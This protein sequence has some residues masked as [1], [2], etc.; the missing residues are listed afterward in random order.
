M[1][2]GLKPKWIQ[3]KPGHAK[4]TPPGAAFVQQGMIAFCRLTGRGASQQ[5][6]GE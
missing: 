4:Q 5:D 6:R 2:C 1:R 3:E